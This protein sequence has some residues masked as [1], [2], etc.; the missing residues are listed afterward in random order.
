MRIEN[1][2]YGSIRSSLSKD[3]HFQVNEV[4]TN[5]IENRSINLGEAP[6]NEQKQGIFFTRNTKFNEGFVWGK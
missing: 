5:S 3:L 4:T 1:S 6:V 2:L